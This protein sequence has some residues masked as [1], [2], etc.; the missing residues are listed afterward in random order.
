MKLSQDEFIKRAVDKHGNKYDYSLVEYKTNRTN[1]KIIC[2][3]HGIFL[4][5]PD[6]HIKSECKKCNDDRKKGNLENF[7]KKANYKHEF[8]Y[9]Y[10]KSIYNGN[11]ENLIIICPDHGE[12]LQTPHNHLKPQWCPKC[13]GGIKDTQEDFINKAKKVHGEK[14]DYSMAVY[15]KSNSLIDIICKKHKSVFKMRPGNHLNGEGCQKCKSRISG[16]EEKWLN[17]IGIQNRQVY[18]KFNNKIAHVDGFDNESNTIYEFYGDY[19]H[20]NPSKYNSSDVN[21]SVKK[22]F[23][24]LYK[25]TIERE[26]L[27]K[28]SGYNIVSIWESDFKKL[29]NV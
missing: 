25:E 17:S 18:I 20:G 19:W 2:P 21:K 5:R 22:T 8:K 11:N 10:S 9:D 12:F 27:F 28:E 23:G 1:V 24:E 6:V 13:N 4:Q 14:Y 26:Y 16:P 3:F 29:Q 7:I 15:V